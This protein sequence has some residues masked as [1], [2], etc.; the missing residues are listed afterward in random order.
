MSNLEATW[1]P[2]DPE[3]IAAL[4]QSDFYM[5]GGRAEANFVGFDVESFEKT[6]VLNFQLHMGEVRCDVHLNLP[7]L[8]WVKEHP[9]VKWDIELGPKLIRIW[10]A[11]DEGKKPT[12]CL[13]WF[14]SEKLLWDYWNG[15]AGIYGLDNYRAFATYD[16]LYVGIAK[17][18]DTYERLIKKAHDARQNI[19]SK[20]PQRYPGARVTDEIILFC[21]KVEPLI[22]KM[23][24]SLNQVKASDLGAE[25]DQK[26]IVRDAEKAF[27]S[28]LK[29]KY[30]I[31]L[32][33]NYPKGK[34]GLYNSDY[35]QYGYAVGEDIIFNTAHGQIR[36]A[37]NADMQIA[38]ND[39]D[40]I[41]IEG[42]KV[43]LVK[44]TVN[45]P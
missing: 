36:G 22:V 43:T 11:V 4:K 42:D 2:N 12:N 28:L 40:L 23:W 21:Y 27:V 7:E 44:P 26:A 34:D 9:C 45:S 5:I 6:K 35:T 3:W 18:T 25:Y 32:F 20:E 17:K 33:A 38:A 10:E 15:M 13:E 19:L 37:W 24:S 41:F 8:P 30:N 16:L 14:T 1:A 31:E 39:A 29:P